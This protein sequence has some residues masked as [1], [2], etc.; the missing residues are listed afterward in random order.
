[1][2][3]DATVTASGAAPTT[4]ADR[5][6]LE[7]L[8]YAVNE[9]SGLYIAVMRTFTRGLTGMLSDQSAA[10]VT[11]ALAEQGL[12]ADED[13]VDA[14]LSYLV[15]HGNLARSPRETEARS[16]ADYLRNRA[17]Y[18]LT[19]RGELVQR[20][21]EELLGHAETAT[22][23]SSEMLGGILHGL[24]DLLS[25]VGDPL[26]RAEPDE[27]AR[28]IGTVF[29]QFGRLVH[30]TREFYTYLTQ[31]LSRYDLERAEFQAFKTA[32]LD[33]L[34]RFVDE[35]TRH[36]PQIADVITQLRPDIGDIC[37]RANAG[38]RLRDLDGRAARRAPGLD[39]ADWSS[40]VAWFTG[41]DSRGS[42]ADGVRRLATEAMRALLVNLRRIVASSDREHGRYAE[43]VRLAG[44]FDTSTD[45][46]AHALWAAAFGL[47]PARHLGF[48]VADGE[49]AVPPTTSWLAAP[50][51][52]VPVQLR[53]SGERRVAGRSGRA[54]DFTA[55][56]RARLAEHARA[57]EARR[58]ALAELAA[59]R[60]PIGRLRVSDAAREALL[61]LYAAGL[62]LRGAA[63]AETAGPGGP[64]G[65]GGPHAP[66]GSPFAARVALPGH[67]C[68]LQI[69]DTPGEGSVIL[70]PSG[71]L[72]LVGRTLAVVPLRDTA[73]SRHA[74]AS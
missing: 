66:G 8:R 73:T 26:S 33:Y 39:P 25:V 12:D 7:A 43:L 18:Q 10:E 52:E 65:P 15:E 20:Q 9:E 19:Q 55:A 21:V 50:S 27:V 17:R 69:E 13:T 37:A 3:D 56:K 63:T 30:S 29:A 22:E 67:E 23:I 44:W 58:A 49:T 6:R 60:G 11:A 51:A 53:Q 4:Q 24:R 14:R 59:H 46:D 35:V 41:S 70:S 16:L 1:M 68:A 62:A 38:Q 61:Q 31:V 47:Y 48:V 28:L 34:Q 2:S 32:L 42:D 72:R 54:E 64:G 74:G 5:V 45:A 36:M 40:L 71:R 57:E